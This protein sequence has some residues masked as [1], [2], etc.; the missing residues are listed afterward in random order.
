MHA[1]SLLSSLIASNRF[2][3]LLVTMRYVRMGQ[4]SALCEGKR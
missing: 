3:Q 2:G 4:M 1:A